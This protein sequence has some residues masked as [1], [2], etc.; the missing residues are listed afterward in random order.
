MTPMGSKPP[1]E[2]EPRPRLDGSMWDAAVVG[3]GPA[4]SMTA[5]A[6]SRTGKSVLLLDRQSFPRWKVCGGTLSPGTRDLLIGAGLG[7]ILQES[8]ARPLQTI[9][10]GGWSIQ[11]DLSLRGSLAL[12]RSVLDSA[13]VQAAVQQG[14]RFYQNATAKL[15]VLSHDGWSLQ[16]SLGDE[17][18]EVHARAVV[19]ADGLGSGLMTRAGVPSRVSS[20]SKRPL[21]GLGGVFL[22]EVSGFES[23]IIHM[24]VGEEGYVGLVRVE[25]GSLNVAA[26]L[27]PVALR[28]AGSPSDVVNSIL[29]G[30]GWEGLPPA[31]ETG[32]KG[33]PELTR[34]PGRLGAERLF[35]VGDAAGYVEPFTGE[36]VLWALSG[37]RRL[38]PLVASVRDVWEPRLLDEWE[39]AHERLVGRAQHLCRATAWVL[40]RPFLSSSLLRVLKSYPNVASPAIRRIGAPLLSSA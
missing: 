1:S 7:Y 37:A 17:R 8:G 25:D 19:A 34:R 18:V 32:W 36:G 27:S 12:S 33:T 29:A 31:P 26:A 10:L 13:L 24:A 14:A 4:G 21:V 23:G 9:R 11:T 3:A 28:R 5:Y 6:L 35:A 38:A 22:P 16:V 39:V 20:S 15:G 30:G 2:G 40:A